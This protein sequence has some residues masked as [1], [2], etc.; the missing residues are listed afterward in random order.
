MYMLWFDNTP[1]KPTTKKIAEAAAHY[2]RKYG[3]QPNYAQVHPAMLPADVEGV[4][5]VSGQH[6]LPNHLLIGMEGSSRG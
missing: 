4:R 5:V 6:I 2:Q 3:Q 1:N